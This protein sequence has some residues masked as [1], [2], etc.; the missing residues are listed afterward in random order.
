MS[1]AAEPSQILTAIL[2]MLL[3]CALLSGVAVLGR[4]AALAGVT[5]FQIVLL[6]L[7][8]AGVAMAPMVALR[9][10]S[11]LRTRHIRL[12]VARVA[13]GFVA[14][15]TWF[16]ALSLVPVGEATA[17]AFLMPLFATMGAAA[18][19]RE[20]VGWRRWG[21]VLVGLFGALVILRPGVIETSPGTTLAIISAIA[22]AGSS[23]FIKRLADRDDPDTV[24]LITTLMQI[25]LALGPGL[26]VWQPLSLELWGVFAAMGLLGMLGHIT[27]ARAF[28]AADASV[29]MGV[30]FARLPFAVLFG[31]WLFGEL[32]DLW[33]W[34]GAAIIFGAAFYT[35]RRESRLQRPALPPD[36]T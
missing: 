34:I 7:V 9:G 29:V 19:L 13:M 22:M 2:W 11:M 32:I 27:M 6:R 26:W 35:A 25:C 24:V 28:R 4:Y 3:S 10:R 14:M 20:Q 5:L 30:D 15:T 33:T 21:A 16:A 8:F 31:W 18:F 23:L 36:R 1:R 12:Y 17:I